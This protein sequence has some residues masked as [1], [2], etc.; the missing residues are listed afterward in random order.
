MVNDS[1]RE[2]SVYISDEKNSVQGSGVLFY[3]GGDSAFVFTCA[4]VVDSLDKVR[5]FILK[6]ID[7]T[8]DLYDVLCT[9]VPASQVVFSPLDE[10][11]KDDAGGENPHRRCRNYPYW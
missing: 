10:V 5:L 6:E 9:E 7:A 4:H 2:Y 11:R 3:A 1:T 8:R